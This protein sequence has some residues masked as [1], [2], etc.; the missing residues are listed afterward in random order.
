MD[1]PLPAPDRLASG[2][3]GGVGLQPRRRRQ[4][5]IGAGDQIMRKGGVAGLLEAD[6]LVVVA[7]TT[8]N[9]CA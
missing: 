2:S 5:S 3:G 6:H 8:A 9:D 1:R 4:G 7:A